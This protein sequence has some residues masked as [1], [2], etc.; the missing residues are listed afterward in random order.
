[1]ITVNKKFRKL[2]PTSQ[3]V[4]LL[5]LGGIALGLTHDPRQ[6]FKIVKD[7]KKEWKWINKRNLHR[8][9]R[10][11]YSSRLIDT[12]DSSDGT[13]TMVLTEFGKKHALTYQ[14]DAITISPMN[15]WDRKWRIVMF[16]VP[17]KHKR[18]RDALSRSLKRMG[19]AQLQKSVFVH[20]FECS[21]VTMFVAEFFNVRQ[22]IRHVLADHI[23]NEA[24][25]KKKFHIT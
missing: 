11:L 19:F 7:I 20:P 15:K 9:I 5:L 17:E 4:L 14:I 13:T 10:N 23:D 24:L 1:M 12:K 3:K 16:D 6:Y 22:Y 2:R 21:K 8:V 18:A 25:L